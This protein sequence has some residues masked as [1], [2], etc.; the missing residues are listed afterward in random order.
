MRRVATFFLIIFATVVFLNL[1]SKFFEDNITIVVVH[2]KTAKTY[3]TGFFIDKRNILT[4]A[5]VVEPAG[6]SSVAGDIEILNEDG[7]WYSTRVVGVDIDSDIAIVSPIDF[8][9]IKPMVPCSRHIAKS[10]VVFRQN[11]YSKRYGYSPLAILSNFVDFSSIYV[12]GE[13]LGLDGSLGEPGVVYIMHDSAII[14]GY[15]GSPLLDENDCYLGMNTSVEINRPKISRAVAINTIE[16]VLPELIKSGKISMSFLGIIF[17]QTLTG[18]FISGTIEGSPAGFLNNHGVRT[19]KDFVRKE[20]YPTHELI[21]INDARINSLDD[22]WR[23][24]Q[25]SP[26]GSLITIGIRNSSGEIELF[27]INSGDRYLMI[28][29]FIPFLHFQHNS[30]AIIA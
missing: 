3:G 7:R 11:F 23:I 20:T 5:H 25:L 16:K 13:V 15:S 19:I 29:K 14:P 17:E 1:F 8:T 22:V 9:N 12:R 27:K 24:L 2:N 26:P 6:N 10:D 4:V 30:Y 28:R 18:V 21:A